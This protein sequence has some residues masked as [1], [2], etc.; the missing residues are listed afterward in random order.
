MESMSLQ[1]EMIAEIKASLKS[2]NKSKKK[3]KVI[4]WLK[5]LSAESP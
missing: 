1:E 2:K 3:A 5:V 4:A